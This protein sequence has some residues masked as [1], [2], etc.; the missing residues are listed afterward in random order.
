MSRTLGIAA[1]QIGPVPRSQSRA[2]TLDRLIALLRQAKRGDC[3]LVVF[4][5]CALTPFFPHWWSED[6]AENDQYCE[7]SMPGPQ[8]QPLFDEAA[9][10]GIG[11]CLGYA[12]LVEEGGH[13]RIYNSAVLVERDGRVV[14]HYRKTHLPG[15]FDHRPGNPFQNLEKRYFEPGDLGYP[16]FEAFGGRVGMLICNDRRWPECYRCLGL[17][18]CELVLI[19]FNTPRHYPEYPDTD[20]L[21]DFH[22]QLSLQAGAYQNGM[23]VVGAAKA[24]VEE[25]VEQ[26]GGSMIVAPSGEV[27]ARSTTLADELVIHRCDLDACRTYKEGVFPPRNRR[28]D[29]FQRL[30]EK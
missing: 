8:T 25:G 27:A 24:G 12:E 16:V 4:T 28:V 5:E 7:R 22:H 18:G 9:S 21:A 6:P 26:I 2:E 30:L 13:K 3:E 14:G 23:W 15:H 19:G 10:L 1:A 11:F 20:R 29:Q 17:Q